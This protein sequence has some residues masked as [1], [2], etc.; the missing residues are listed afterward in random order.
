MTEDD[1]ARAR[2]SDAARNDGRVWGFML[3]ETT[4]IRL[5]KNPLLLAGLG[6]PP[7]DGVMPSGVVR[8]VVHDP[9]EV[10]RERDLVDGVPLAQPATGGSTS[11]TS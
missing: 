2:V 5:P 3:D 8:H 10:V 9:G 1:E 11:G 7:F 4:F 6:P